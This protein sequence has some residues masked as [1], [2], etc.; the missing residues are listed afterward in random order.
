MTN[1]FGRVQA[2]RTDVH[3]ILNPMAA[4]HAEG[5]VQTGQAVIRSGIAAVGE[6][7]IRLQQTSGADETVGVPPEGRATGGAA[8]AKNAFVQAIQLRPVLGGL[9]PLNSRCR[10]VVL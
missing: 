2:L 3:T 6:K 7:A 9:E 1:C 4:K 5:V 8:S 10:T